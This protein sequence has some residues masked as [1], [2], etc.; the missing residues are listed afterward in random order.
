[1]L[2]HTVREDIIFEVHIKVREGE[3]RSRPSMD[4]AIGKCTRGGRGTD[5]L[6]QCLMTPIASCSR[7]RLLKTE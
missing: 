7:E 5:G 4:L 3:L 1:M 2:I 6:L